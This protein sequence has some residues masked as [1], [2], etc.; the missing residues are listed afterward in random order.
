MSSSTPPATSSLWFP[1][2]APGWVR[3]I[4][5]YHLAVAAAL[6]LITVIF[7]AIIAV[8]FLISTNFNLLGAVE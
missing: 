6:G 7:V 5:P 3:Q 2:R 4:R 1:R 8:L